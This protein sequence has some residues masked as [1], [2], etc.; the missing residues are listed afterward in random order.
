VYAAAAETDQLGSAI[1]VL[2]CISPHP[3]HGDPLRVVDHD[4]HIWRDL[5]AAAVVGIF[6]R[7]AELHAEFNPVSPRMPIF[8]ERGDLFN[9][10]SREALTYLE[11][12]LS[13]GGRPPFDV[14]EIHDKRLAGL[15]LEDR[16]RFVRSWVNGGHVKIAPTG[17]GI[18]RLLAQ[19]LSFAPGQRDASAELVAAFA[20]AAWIERQEDA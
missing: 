12:T 5:N 18:N 1:G 7:L 17:S 4:V 10:L 8:A 16:A 15:S 19:L 6:Q 13:L 3:T 2:F 11:P 14:V 20:L 9:K